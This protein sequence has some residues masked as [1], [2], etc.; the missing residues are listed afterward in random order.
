[1]LCDLIFCFNLT[2]VITKPTHIK[3]GILDTLITNTG[4]LIGNSVYWKSYLYFIL[5]WFIITIDINIT[6]H[7]KKT[8]GDFEGLNNYFLDVY[9]IPCFFWYW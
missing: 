5:W 4:N 9:F 2:E 1:M 8:T 6:H 3:G 7:F